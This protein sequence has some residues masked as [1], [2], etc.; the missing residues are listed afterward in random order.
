MHLS[1]GPI[2][3]LWLHSGGEQR[4]GGDIEQ[5]RKQERWPCPFSVAAMAAGGAGATAA[6]EEWQQRPTMLVPPSLLLLHRRLLPPAAPSTPPP[7]AAVS[8]HLRPFFRRGIIV[9]CAS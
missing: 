6:I 1:V 4:G 3:L 7:R 9:H 8:P 5:G 2:P